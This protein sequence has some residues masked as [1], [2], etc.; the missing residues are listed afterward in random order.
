MQKLMDQVREFM[1]AAG[2]RIGSEPG[3]VLPKDA[4]LGLK[5]IEEE[6]TEFQTALLTWKALTIVH[7]ET[8]VLAEIADA[9][10]DLLYVV[11][12]TA[13]A[14]G[15]PMAEIMDEI[16]RSNMTKFGPGAS[17]DPET[18]KVR[19]PPDWTPPNIKA[20]LEKKK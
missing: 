12:W 9:L 5:L 6:L 17:K 14:F 18:G 1:K 10:G 19:K 13:L 7:S 20:L 16:Q 4:N 8:E 2:Q 11:T 15:F 3:D